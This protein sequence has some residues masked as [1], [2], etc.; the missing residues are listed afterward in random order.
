M[1]APSRAALKAAEILAAEID[2]TVLFGVRPYN[3]AN[4]FVHVT[5]NGVTHEWDSTDV[6]TI[7]R[8]ARDIAKAERVAARD[9]E[10]HAA[11]AD[12]ILAAVEM[13]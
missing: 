9:T 7:R 13:M 8:I 1:S 10:A 11:K 12:R 6:G 5:Y 2:E 3:D 4:W